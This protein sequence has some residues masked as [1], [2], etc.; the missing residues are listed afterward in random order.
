TRVVVVSDH[1]MA[2]V[3]TVIDP[4][5]LLLAKGYLAV[6]GKGKIVPEKTAV[7]AVSDGGLSHLY[8]GPR[9]GAEAARETVVGARRA[10]FAGWKVDGVP[11]LARILTRREA[12]A[13]GLDHPAS[14]DLLLFAQPGYAFQGRGD[15]RERRAAIPADVYGMHGYLNGNP[16]MN[17]IYLV[18][19]AG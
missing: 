13:V 11:P 3:H 12:A 2:P 17:A 9:A 4:N 19:G 1:G 8:L 6:D 16:E 7:F 10:L 15:L 5:V 18:L 14:G